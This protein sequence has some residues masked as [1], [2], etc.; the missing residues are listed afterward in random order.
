MSIEPEALFTAALS[1]PRDSRATLAD[2]LWDSLGESYSQEVSEAW[3]H[4]AERRIAAF[5]KGE[6]KAIPGED[7][8]R[9]LR[10]R[11]RT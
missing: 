8:F 2:L 6:T 10:E 3:L 1:L 9:S 7:V 4:E 11:R 5:D